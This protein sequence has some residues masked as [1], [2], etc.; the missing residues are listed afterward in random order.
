[1]EQ[2]LQGKPICTQ[3]SV[4]Q[5]K[6]KQTTSLPPIDIYYISAIGFYQTLA[7]TDATPFV[8][9]LYEINRIIEEKEAEAILKD[10]A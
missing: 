6:R 1:M 2:E 10:T 5:A 3:L 7:K 4:K 8:T 9:S